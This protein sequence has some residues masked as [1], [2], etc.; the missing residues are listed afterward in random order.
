MF[1]VAGNHNGGGKGCVA[2]AVLGSLP[3]VV[4]ARSVM[5]VL[6]LEACAISEMAGLEWSMT[7]GCVR[8]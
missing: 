2:G 4:L 7:C 1:A 5:S 3:S 6:F 8:L